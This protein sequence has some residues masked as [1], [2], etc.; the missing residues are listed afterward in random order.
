MDDKR[1]DSRRDFR[2]QRSQSPKFRDRS[3]NRLIELRFQSGRIHKVISRNKKRNDL[4]SRI[5]SGRDQVG[6][7]SREY[8]K[9][10]KEARSK[11]NDDSK[12][13]ESGDEEKK[14]DE[15]DESEVKSKHDEND[16]DF[17]DIGNDVDL[18]DDGEASTSKPK[19]SKKSDE[20]DKTE[21][22]GEKSEK[23]ESKKS[24]LKSKR[25]LIAFDCPHCEL[26]TTSIRVRK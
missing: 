1:S 9:R 22:D 20:T 23:K 21:K 24:P 7:G 11:L 4:I 2:H 19:E 13:S 14:D 26:N 6:T 8:L 5:I 18:E 25:D 3:P 12:R 10:M 16:E 15:N 17:L